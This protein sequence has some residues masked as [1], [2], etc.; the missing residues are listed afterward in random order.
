MPKRIVR[1][2]PNLPPP[3]LSFKPV[4]IYARVSTQRSSQFSSISAQI[5]ALVQQVYHTYQ[6]KLADVYIDFS[7]GRNTENRSEFQR[8]LNDCRQ[9]KINLILVK[10]ISRFAREVVD[11]LETIRELKS[12]GIPVYF[13]LEE[14]NSFQPDFELYYS[15]YAAIAQGEQENAR[16]NVSVAIRQRVKD[17]TSEL[18]SRACYGYRKDANGDFIIVPEEADNVRLIYRLYLEGKSIIA[19]SRELERR[20]IPSPT[21]KTTWC[22]RAIDTLLSNEKYRGNSVA[23]APLMSYDSKG[24]QRSKY[25]FSEHHMAIIDSEKFDAVAEEKKRRSNIE[26]DENGVHRKHTKYTST[27]KTDDRKQKE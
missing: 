18:Y 15:I 12:I 6:W 9:K 10:S 22:R 1:R 21:G 5:S 11:G 13:D 23:T 16:D 19:I 24:K 27:M 7:S 20:G 26:Y 2:I 25:M 8:L 3:Q 17:G 4:G 14:M